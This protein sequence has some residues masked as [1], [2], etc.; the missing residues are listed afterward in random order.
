MLQALYARVAVPS[1]YLDLAR[2]IRRGWFPQILT[3][4]YD[5]LLEKA[6][7]RVGVPASRIQVTTLARGQTSE[8]RPGSP[9]ASLVSIVKLHG[10]LAQS[11]VQLTP[12]D[13]ARALNACRRLVSDELLGH[14]IVVGHTAGDDPVDHFFAKSP[15]RELLVGER[16]ATAARR[17]QLVR[18]TRSTTWSARSAGRRPSSPSFRSGSSTPPPRLPSPV[19]S[20]P[21]IRSP[22]A[23][24]PFRAR[25]KP[26]AARS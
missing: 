19:S 13:I 17:A 1:F 12:T 15:D 3:T 4:S 21:P 8:N 7:D 24:L 14:L 25:R 6:L 11:V 22:R 5:N 23:K 20:W 9:E 16:A 18:P 2:L 26:S 10:D